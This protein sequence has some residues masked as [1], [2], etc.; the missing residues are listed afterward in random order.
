[1]KRVAGGFIALILLL[2][3]VFLGTKSYFFSIGYKQPIFED[4]RGIR[5]I[6]RVVDK[7]FQILDAQGEWQDSFLA[8]VNIG[9]GIP[10]AFP[11]EYA[12]SYETYFQWFTQ[13]ARSGSNT[14]RVYTPQT[15]GFYQ[16][17]YE[18]NRLAATP[19]YLLQGVYMDENDVRRY[20]DVFAPG[21]IAI[22]DMSQDII[23]CVNM[24]HGNAVITE[25]AGKASGVYRYDVSEYV[26]GWILG[27]ECEAHLVEGTNLAH[28]EMTSFEGEYVY[29]KDVSPFE[30]F[31]AQMKELTIAYETEHYR[32]QRPVAFSNWTTTDPLKHPNEPFLNEDSAEIDV[33][34]IKATA[35]FV[36]GF[37]ASYHVYPYYAEFLNYPSG[38]PQTDANP[39]LAYLKRLVGYHNMPVIISEFGLPTS[40]GVTHINYLT[41][42]NQGGHSEQSQGEGLIS[43][44]DDIHASGC[45]GGIVFSWQDEWFKRS[46]NT[47]DFDDPDARPL[48]HNVQS[49]EVNFGLT[50]FRAFPSIQIDG[51]GDDWK[52]AAALGDGL[53]AKWDE[54]YLYLRVEGE[55]ILRQKFLI[56]IDTIAGQGSGF[57]GGARFER[58]ADFLLVLDGKENTRLMIDPYYNPDYKLNGE[59][60]FTAD[61]LAAFEKTGTGEFRLVRQVISRA[62]TM[63]LTG[64]VIPPQLF[65][66]GKLV[67]GISNPDSEAFNSLGD[68][69]AGDGFAEIR[70]PWM[71]L[72]FA[73]P[74]AGEILGNLH[75]DQQM[76][77]QTVK[78]LY[79][80]LGREDDSE[81]IAMRPFA[82]PSWKGLSWTQRMKSSYDIIAEAFPRYATYPLGGDA[83]MQRARQLSDTRLLYI[84]LEHMLGATDSVLI[85]LGLSSLLA[86]YLFFVL[87][88]VNIRL[89]I[90]AAKHR[91]EWEHLR[92]IMWL[93]GEE[94]DKRIHQSFLCSTSGLD[95]LSQFLTKECSWESEAPL[96][97]ALRHGRYEQCMLKLM[98]TKDVQMITLVIRVAGQLR[99]KHYEYYILEKMAAHKDNPELLY[100]GLLSLSLM[101][102]RASLLHLC[103]QP[104]Y[105][106]DLSFRSLKEIFAV[107]SGD[108][109][110]LFKD[111]LGSSDPY[112]RRIAI[113]NIGDEGLMDL[114]DD[115]LPMMETE[116][117]N[118]RGDLIRTFGQLR[119][120]RA[121]ERISDFIHNPDWTI[122]NAAV[123]ALAAIDARQYLPS[124]IQ[125]LKDK[126]WWVRY[127]SAKELRDRIPADEL[128][129]MI[130]GLQDR[131][132]GEILRYAL[133]EKRL[134]EKGGSDS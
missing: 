85:L 132:A 39:Y 25:K 27:I 98:K 41:G 112:V 79:I 92:S 101:G 59:I 15:P 122:R 7:S 129:A 14:I 109:T 130:P 65:D 26:I 67:Y 45:M 69:Y 46:W 106:K 20:S 100:A 90:T 133:E 124:L 64:Q 36:P 70:I 131:F 54:S 120:V 134:M 55:D 52:G 31:I 58:A 42:L 22:R 48:W 50:A 117:S 127:N 114:A 110:G 94:I 4:E 126:E 78:E 43:L 82:L 44:L 13:I 66:T 111:L 125:G 76:T 10:G 29:A 97:Q 71:L 75:S 38:D 116:D 91:R 83:Q 40:R 73:D 18:F 30:V 8:G 113:K 87:V 63:P 119:F 21:S 33:E 35:S 84:R 11:G 105:T 68:F 77:Y 121:G 118:L 88:A 107:Y 57:T 108:K 81:P 53:L 123:R 61:E 74:S 17:L 72:N 104:D 96:I 103:E 102:R 2:V 49:S 6:S 34:K 28:P 12:I 86:L 56:P 62:L 89:N 60:M 24:L 47:M 115:L 5:Y 51:Q 19:L 32:M 23:D 95:L 16:A 37:F 128:Q 99:L 80:G 9:L 1:M 3:L 93:T